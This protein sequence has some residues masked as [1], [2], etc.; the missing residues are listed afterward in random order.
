MNFRLN[1][2]KFF[3]FLEKRFFYLYFLKELI[4]EYRINIKYKN[5]FY[6]K[7][8]K[9]EILDFNYDILIKNK[10]S[11]TLFI[12]GSGSSI[13]NISKEMWEHIK[14]NDSLGFNFWLIHE[15]IPNYYMFEP[16]AQK[17]QSKI[18]QFWLRERAISYKK[19]ATYILMKDFRTLSMRYKDIP[20]D[21]RSK[22]ML[23][24]K[25]N[26]YGSTKENIIKSFNLIKRFKL[27]SRN[28]VY[29]RRASLFSAIYIGWRLGYK[30]IVLAGID[31]NN[32]DYFYESI[33]Y[34]GILR[35]LIKK[36]KVHDTI[37]DNGTDLPIDELI[38]ILNDYLLKE[39]NTELYVLN[40]NSLLS[41]KLEIYNN[42]K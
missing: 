11:D 3:L 36:D 26:V 6:S 21:L 17:E 33:E 12:L 8:Y 2:K 9:H 25:D 32:A 22:F 34:E 23:L 37:K 16:T 35:P 38:Y 29:M 18:L 30:K 1:K 7:Y 42:F 41:T 5:K 15:H 28:V 14:L 19:M 39:S 4:N 40:K 10:K 13:N 24:P 31:L 27:F 20:E